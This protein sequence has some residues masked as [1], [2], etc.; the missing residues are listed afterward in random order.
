MENRIFVHVQRERDEESGELVETKY[1]VLI[2][3]IVDEH[4]L[5]FIRNIKTGKYFQCSIYEREH[6]ERLKWFKYGL[7]SLEK[8]MLDWCVNGCVFGD[9]D[10][11][12]DTE[13]EYIEILY[14]PRHVNSM[15]S[16]FD[17]FS[18]ESLI[19]SAIYGPYVD[20]KKTVADLIKKSDKMS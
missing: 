18:I 2:D 17:L 9:W 1:I 11:E 3:K 5:I 15:S 19:T 6:R 16:A 8:V 14:E 4:L 10:L 13:S 20:I 12:I 7:E